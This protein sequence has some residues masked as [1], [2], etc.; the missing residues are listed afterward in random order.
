MLI[1]IFIKDKPGGSITS[2]RWEPT[3]CLR[4]HTRKEPRSWI[5][6]PDDSPTLQGSRGAHAIRPKPRV[7]P[8][9]LHA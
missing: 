6:P 1:L 8:I 9:L 3:A 7:F 5:R 4:E 2:T